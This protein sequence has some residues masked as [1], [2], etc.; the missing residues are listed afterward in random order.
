[1]SFNDYLQERFEGVEGTEELRDITRHGLS[2][3]VSGF[4]YYS[5][6]Y[7]L[8]LDFEEEI[9]EYVAEQTGMSFSDLATNCAGL[10]DLAQYAVW[11]YVECWAQTEYENRMTTLEELDRD[12][13]EHL[14]EYAYAN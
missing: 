5:E 6:L 9:L 3:G 4:I 1:M 2:G 10:D 13:V 8:F 11:T 7:T 14:M 12:N